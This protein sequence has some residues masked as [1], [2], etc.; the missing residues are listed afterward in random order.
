MTDRQLLQQALEALEDYEP[1]EAHKAIAALR[2]A[3]AQPDRK[4]PLQVRVDR[5]HAWTMRDT[6]CGCDHNEYCE[7]CWPLDF[8]KGGY[9]DQQ[10]ALATTPPSAPHSA[11]SADTFCKEP[12]AIR[13]IA[14]ALRQHE[15]T[16]IRTA[17]GFDV[18]SLNQ[19]DAYEK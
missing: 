14:K 5:D 10:E 8:R 12:E 19:L 4:H 13:Q 11:D 6:N 17:S 1:N 18:V 16:L 9:W 7:K 2:K 15:L 3:L